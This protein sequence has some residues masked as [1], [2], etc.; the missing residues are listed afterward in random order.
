MAGHETRCLNPRHEAHDRYGGRGIT[1]C[2]RWRDSFAAFLV[3]M[4]ERPEGTTLDRIDVD[5]NY[6]PGNCR[7]ATAKEQ[8]NRRRR[9]DRM[10]DDHQDQDRLLA[11][12][13]EHLGLDD[14]DTV[15]WGH[16]LDGGPILEV[17]GGAHASIAG[18]TC[19]LVNDGRLAVLRNMGGRVVGAVVDETGT[20][21][22]L[23][24]Y[25]PADSGHDPGLN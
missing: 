8:A 11:L 10:T 1:V 5:G 12:A 14:D 22:Q 21:H 17:R 23:L 24:D 4:G 15:T 3:D 13:G 9:G 2:D 18:A 16:G 19:C 20:E 7:W 25:W 6:E